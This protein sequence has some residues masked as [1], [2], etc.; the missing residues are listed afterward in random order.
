MFAFAEVEYVH[1]RERQAAGIDVARQK[2]VYRGRKR[3]TTKAMPKRAQELRTSGLTDRE[4]A[5]ALG[6]S[7]RTVQRYLNGAQ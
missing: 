2:G 6:I 1:I 7:R 5:T 3:G 4:I